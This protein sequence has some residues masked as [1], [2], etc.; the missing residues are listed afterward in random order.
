MIVYWTMRGSES[1]Q[2]GVQTL[3]E[4]KG[5]ILE[6]LHALVPTVAEAAMREIDATGQW[7]NGMITAAIL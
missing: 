2:V 6:K 3:E 7:T 4:G 5:K 1:M